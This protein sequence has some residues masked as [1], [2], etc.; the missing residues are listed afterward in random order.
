MWSGP[1]VDKLGDFI[2]NNY[3]VQNNDVDDSKEILKEIAEQVD[4]SIDFDANDDNPEISDVDVLMVASEND[5]EWFYMI[6]VNN[7]IL[8]N[9]SLVLFVLLAIYLLIKQP[10][11][12]ILL[13][14]L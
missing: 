6:I 11:K 10:I 5:S 1:G 8:I 7:S 13:L 3:S 9:Q 14:Q 2:K 4:L 12:R